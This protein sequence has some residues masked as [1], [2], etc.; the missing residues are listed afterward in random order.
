MTRHFC[1]RCGSEAAH[2]YL[3]V[4]VKFEKRTKLQLRAIFELVTEPSSGGS[5]GLLSA[6]TITA[7]ICRTC[8]IELVEALKLKIHNAGTRP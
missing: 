8:Q 1:D 5:L 7:D 6:T 4:S 3:E 2:P